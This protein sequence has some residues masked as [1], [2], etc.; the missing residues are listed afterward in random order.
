MPMSARDF[1][2]WLREHLSTGDAQALTGAETA[3]MRQRLSQVFLHDID[4]AMGDT[5]HQAMLNRIH[6]DGITH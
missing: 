2:I 5:A 6:R 1:C 4:P 3:A